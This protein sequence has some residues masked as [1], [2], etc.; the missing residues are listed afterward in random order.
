MSVLVLGLC[1][2]ILAS[3]ISGVVSSFPSKCIQAVVLG[4]AISG[5]FAVICQIVSLSAHADP[6]ASAMYYFICADML[7]IIAFVAYL[8]ARKTVSGF[9][10]FLQIQDL[11]FEYIFFLFLLRLTFLFSTFFTAL[12]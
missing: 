11:R 10:A 9:N 1:T 6:R 8:I 4:Q 2:G 7:L 3:S 12:L 5:I